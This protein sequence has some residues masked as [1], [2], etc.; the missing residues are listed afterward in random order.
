LKVLVAGGYHSGKSSVIRSL[1][2]GKSIHI[3]KHGTTVALDYGRIDVEGLKIHLFGT[4]GMRHFRVLRE[5]LSKGADGVL[6]VID[7]ADP[8]RDEEAAS[9]KREIDEILPD[10]TRVYL[11]NKQDVDGARRPEIIRQV[12]R[13]PDDVPVIGTSTVTGLNLMLAL[14]TLL[15]KL[16]EKVAPLL[17]VLVRYDGKVGGISQ[18]AEAMMF[19]LASIRKVFNWLE[20][21]GYVEV[22]WR[23][24]I[25]WLVPPIKSI[26]EK[27][28]EI[29]KGI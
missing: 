1:S 3:D 7:S 9:V 18:F 14:K 26:L 2:G 25:F 20:L 15:A 12:F 21:R 10:V 27:P 6:F 8:G 23:A 11:A 29:L 24:G 4:P 17:N 19:N 13:I 28:D 22:D 16:I 5:V